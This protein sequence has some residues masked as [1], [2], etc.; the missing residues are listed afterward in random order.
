MFP[1]EWLWWNQYRRGQELGVQDRHAGRGPE[2]DKEVDEWRGGQ[3]GSDTL[4]DGQPGG[5]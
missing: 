4:G 3:A 5:T 1:G 2:T